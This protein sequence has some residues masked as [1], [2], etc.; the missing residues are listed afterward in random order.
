MIVIINIQPRDRTFPVQ[1]HSSFNT[2]LRECQVLWYAFKMHHSKVAYSMPLKK[3]TD[4]PV[5]HIGSAVP[6]ANKVEPSCIIS[7]TLELYTT[8]QPVHYT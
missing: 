8:E 1:T 5:K 4:P 3:R 6:A 2:H 7:L